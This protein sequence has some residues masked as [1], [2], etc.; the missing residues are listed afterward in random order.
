MIR[1]SVKFP[2]PTVRFLST[3]PAPAALEL[4]LDE[5][6]ALPEPPHAASS[7]PRAAA[8]ARTPTR[9]RPA[10]RTRA[11]VVPCDGAVISG[12]PSVSRALARVS[13][14]RVTPQRGGRRRACPDG[15]RCCPLPAPNRP[16]GR[17]AS[18]PGSQFGNESLTRGSGE[19]AA[20]GRAGAAAAPW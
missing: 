16:R 13:G 20:A 4:E 6:N 8:D 2:P 7:R 3:V 5:E 14:G 17:S 15:P 18:R 19:H 10:P 11:G 1:N 12:S 9:R